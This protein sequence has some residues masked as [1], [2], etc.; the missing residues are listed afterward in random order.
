MRFKKT[1][2]CQFCSKIK[3][4]CQTCLLDLQYNL[5]VQVRDSVLK[6]E[7]TVPKMQINRMFLTQKLE[8]DLA[9]SNTESLVDYGKADPVGKDLLKSISRREPYYKRNLPHVCSFFI[10]GTCKRGAECPYRH[11][12]DARDE[13]LGTQKIKDRYYGTNDP[14]A[15]KILDKLPE[16][17]DSSSLPSDPT[18]TTIALFGNFANVGEPV[19]KNHFVTFGDVCN[20]RI[21]AGSNCAFVKFKTREAANEAISAQGTSCKLGTETFRMAWAK[22]KNQLG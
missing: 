2:I 15:T 13:Q 4:V 14:V 22:T 11:E 21:L 12:I 9:L 3:N 6:I 17:F 18:I 5:P 7:N 16:H 8:S 20:V 1:E 19:I 10:K